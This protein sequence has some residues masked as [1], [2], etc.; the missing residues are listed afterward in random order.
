MRTFIHY[1][2]SRFSTEKFEPIKNIEFRNKPSGGLWASDIKSP[3]GWFEW[4][5]NNEFYTERNTPDNCFRFRLS[6]SAK[7]CT[8]CC[9]ADI[10]KLPIKA[11]RLRS[12]W[13]KK[14]IPDFEEAIRRGYDVI[15]YRL[16]DDVCGGF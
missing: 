15:D 14:Y 11:K 5:E 13:T 10:E 7:I 1:G 12:D 9:E 4:C 6:E 8:L 2:D 3:Y 16:S